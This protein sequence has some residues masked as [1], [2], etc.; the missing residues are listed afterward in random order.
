MEEYTPLFS[1]AGNDLH[2]LDEVYEN[3]F[4]KWVLEMIHKYV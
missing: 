2:S 3:D 4:P 1:T